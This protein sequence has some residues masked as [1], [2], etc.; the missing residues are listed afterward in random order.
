[1]QIK[2]ILQ[3][4]V[5][6]KDIEDAERMVSE[7]VKMF[8][9]ALY[10]HSM[11]KHH[12]ES[13]ELR[14][15]RESEESKN[16]SAVYSEA[17][18]SVTAKGEGIVCRQSIAFQRTIF[19]SQAKLWEEIRT[20]AYRHACERSGSKAAARHARREDPILCQKRAKASAL[21]LIGPYQGVQRDAATIEKQP[22]NRTKVYSES[23]TI[24]A[25]IQSR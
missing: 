6:K 1:M 20:R 22:T 21:C 15:V 24:Q 16:K 19:N 5:T 23:F 13:I 11:R 10:N 12:N 7:V 2:H 8:D 3:P 14:A 18:V 25:D 17:L 4:S 9:A